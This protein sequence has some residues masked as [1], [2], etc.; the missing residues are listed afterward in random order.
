MNIGMLWF[1]NDP[2]TE[3]SQK[4]ARAAAYYHS[5]YRSAPNLCIVN[6]KMVGKKTKAG[7]ISI[8]ANPAI[9]PNHFWIGLQDR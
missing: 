8:E 4:V 9:L 7:C 3:L 1:D 5:K 6:P 2:K